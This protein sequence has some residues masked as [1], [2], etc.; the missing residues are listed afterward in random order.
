MRVNSGYAWAGPIVNRT[1]KSITLSPFHRVRLAPP[2]TSDICGFTTRVITAADVGKRAAIAC[3]LEVKRMGEKPEPDQ[4]SFLT[5]VR[6]F[7]GIS[8]V[9]TDAD[10]AKKIIEL[11]GT[12]PLRRY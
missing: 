11:D 3:V 2:G 6:H 12:W 9:A 5:M 1:P 8:G 7:G 4:E 10:S